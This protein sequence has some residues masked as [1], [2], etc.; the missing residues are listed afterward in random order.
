MAFLVVGKKFVSMDYVDGFVFI[1]KMHFHAFHGVMEQ[2]RKVGGDYS[3]DVKIKAD[4]SNAIKTDAVADTIDYS[5]VYQI[6]KKIME[7]PSA[8]LEHVA[9]RMAESLFAKFPQ[10][11]EIVIR[12]TKINPPMGADCQGAGVEISFSNG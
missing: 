10:T 6:I 8:L 5:V 11:K 9:G 1:K 7:V 3:V 12:I 2:E 4:I